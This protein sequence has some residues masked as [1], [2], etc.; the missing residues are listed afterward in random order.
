MRY[1]FRRPVFLILKKN[2]IEP[3][4]K[5]IMKEDRMAYKLILSILEMQSSITLTIW[6][7]IARIN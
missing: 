2:I 6:E 3:L 7:E 5:K 1:L 4:L